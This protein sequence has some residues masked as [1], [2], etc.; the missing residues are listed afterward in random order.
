MSDDDT[1]DT[2]DIEKA[3]KEEKENIAL[4]SFQ[5]ADERLFIVIHPRGNGRVDVRS[6]D[7][8]DADDINDGHVLLQGL[9]SML[10]CSYDFLMECGH[11]EIVRK[12]QLELD[13]SNGVESISDNV[14]RVK[15]NKDM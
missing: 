1:F 3:S 10:D 8:T 5:L 6:Y 15:F 13:S 9:I 7:T 12:L 14:I 4:E 2:K 11:K